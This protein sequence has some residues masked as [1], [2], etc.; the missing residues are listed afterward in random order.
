MKKLGK[1][2]IV[3]IGLAVAFSVFASAGTASATST[4]PPPAPSCNQEFG[5]V[6]V[7]CPGSPTE[8]KTGSENEEL[9]RV[10]TRAIGYVMYIVGALSVIMIIVGGIMYSTAS[11]DEAKVGKAKKVITGAIIGLAFALLASVIIAF[12]QRQI[13]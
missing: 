7:T 13:S 1:T 8:V 3:A 10:I 11:G 4:A 6:T 12:V 5:S 9:D 2:L